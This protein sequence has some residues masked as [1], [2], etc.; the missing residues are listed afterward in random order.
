MLH[1]SVH[2]NECYE[3]QADRAAL[4]LSENYEVQKFSHDEELPAYG[5]IHRLKLTKLSISSKSRN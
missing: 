1:R 5:Y 4:H 2:G 3:N